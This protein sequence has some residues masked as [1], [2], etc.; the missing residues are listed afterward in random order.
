MMMMLPV[1]SGCSGDVCCCGCGRDVLVYVELGCFC[2]VGL[3][4]VLLLLL[5]LV[6]VVVVV[7]EL[8]R[9]LSMRFCLPACMG[10]HVSVSYIYKL[11]CDVLPFCF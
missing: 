11:C 6:V 9:G 10:L 7:V 4:I 8:V 5:S 2:F 3:G 1:L